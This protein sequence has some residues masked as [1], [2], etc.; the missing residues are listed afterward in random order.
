[1]HFVHNLIDIPLQAEHGD[2]RNRRILTELY[3]GFYQGWEARE[4][5]WGLGGRVGLLGWV[6]GWWGW[7]GLCF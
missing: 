5:T 2:S 4:D 6:G 7:V 3:F 1:M